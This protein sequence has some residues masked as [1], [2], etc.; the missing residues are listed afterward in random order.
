MSDELGKQFLAERPRGHSEIGGRGNEL[1]D[2]GVACQVEAERPV[3]PV[4]ADSGNYYAFRMGR[5]G[6]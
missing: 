6:S 3:I 5:R 4:G 2:L 1:G